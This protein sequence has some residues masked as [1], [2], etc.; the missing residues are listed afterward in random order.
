M[1]APEVACASVC[2]TGIA[3]TM[4]NG[5]AWYVDAAGEK[6]RIC[7]NEHWHAVA[8]STNGIIVLTRRGSAFVHVHDTNTGADTEIIVRPVPVNHAALAISGDGTQFA[9]TGISQVVSIWDIGTGR[10]TRTF[11]GDP[12]VMKWNPRRPLL[13]LYATGGNTPVTE[14]RDTRTGA[15]VYTLS[16]NIPCMWSID[17]SQ[18]ACTGSFD[19]Y[20]HDAADGHRV[21][22]IRGSNPCAPCGVCPPLPGLVAST[23]TS[24]FGRGISVRE[25]RVGGWSPHESILVPEHRPRIRAMTWGKNLGT[26]V[27][28][29]DDGEVCTVRWGKDRPRARSRATAREIA[30]MVDNPEKLLRKRRR[31]APRST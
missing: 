17:G 21:E 31:V 2:A 16:A 18:I 24:F 28:L 29:T 8:C 10:S 22:T 4:D 5:D 27:F 26:I 15:V 1:S 14:V 19:I 30:P 12:T 3:Y 7:P 11:K 6:R 23:F 25:A 20:I 13:L 9:V